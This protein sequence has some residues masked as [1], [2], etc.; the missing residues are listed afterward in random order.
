VLPVDL[1]DT[2]ITNRA[3]Y[4]R[5]NIQ[6]NVLIALEL[7]NELFWNSGSFEGAARQ[8]IDGVRNGYYGA[9]TEGAPQPT[10]T[11][12]FG[13]NSYL[14][15]VNTAAPAMTTGQLI[16]VQSYEGIGTCI[17]RALR[18]VTAGSRIYEGADFTLEF[19]YT[20]CKQA[21]RR[22]YAVRHNQ[23]LN[24]YQSVFGTTRFNAQSAFMPSRNA[25]RHAIG[26]MSRR[27]ILTRPTTLLAGTNSP[28]HSGPSRRHGVTPSA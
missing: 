24:I 27:A 12:A 7:G 5:D 19:D 9:A 25:S 11:V 3:T 23:I 2:D 21:G 18:T 10:K 8:M 26:T 20:A 6:S 28:P 22:W 13:V 15:T 16:G 1:T 4:Q 17:W 14:P